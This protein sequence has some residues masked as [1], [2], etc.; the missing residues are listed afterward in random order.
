M[1]IEQIK[2]EIEQ[3]NT[4][5]D[6]IREKTEKHSYTPSKASTPEELAAEHFSA[7]LSKAFSGQAITTTQSDL[8]VYY[9]N[10]KIFVR[11]DI[12]ENTLGSPR[13]EKSALFV[14]EDGEEFTKVLISKYLGYVQFLNN[15]FIIIDWDKGIHY[16]KDG[17]HWDSV[18][19]NDISE[20]C[21][22]IEDIIH[23][24][25]K[26]IVLF[27]DSDDVQYIAQAKKIK[28]GWECFELDDVE[29]ECNELGFSDDTYYLEGEN[30]DGLT[31]V[32]TS[33][34][35]EYW[36]EADESDA[37]DPD[38]VEVG[39]Y[40]IEEDE[41]DDNLYLCKKKAPHDPDKI[42]NENI[43]FFCE[44]NREIYAKELPKGKKHKLTEAPFDVKAMFFHE[45]NLLL[46][47]THL[48][49]AAAEVSISE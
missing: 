7:A 12:F 11:L 30:E 23:D 47:G 28:T 3:K 44:N 1:N 19:N 18:S 16:S 20:D 33:D 48:E 26:Y 32:Y 9:L 29:A 17:Y 8:K 27:N 25:K 37:S 4:P 39:E 34:D 46:F 31:V 42:Y 14:S 49:Y 15:R 43:F 21:R 40:Y 38:D 35:A 36:Y 5:W 10:E 6:A 24:G 41:D 13:R 22:Y 2:L 45:G